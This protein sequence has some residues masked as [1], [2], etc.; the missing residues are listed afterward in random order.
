MTPHVPPLRDG[1]GDRRSVLPQASLLTAL[2]LMLLLAWWPRPAAAQGPDHIDLVITGRLINAHADPVVG[3]AVEV[4]IDG[5]SWPVLVRVTPRKAGH[6]AEDGSFR[7]TLSV[8]RDTLSD[9]AHGRAALS[10]TV[11]KPTHRTRTILVQHAGFAGPE[12]LADVGPV[13]MVRLVNPSFIIAGLTFLLVFALISFH[14]LHETVAALLGMGMIFG[15]PV[16]VVT[17][18]LSTIWLLVRY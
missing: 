14:V 17:L 9:I 3:A 1:L 15:V 8:P 7:L 5:R 6:S 10:I 16:T 11:A 13:T 12:L 4:T 2:V 18:L